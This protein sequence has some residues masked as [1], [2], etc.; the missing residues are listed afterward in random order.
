A[1][2]GGSM[3]SA[4]LVR[5]AVALTVA[6]ALA[7]LGSPPAGSPTL[8]L[9]EVA[10]PP[11][12]VATALRQAL[13]AKGPGYEPRT[14]HRNPDGTPKYTNRLLLD[15]TPSLPQHAHT[16]VAGSPWGE[17]ASER[18]RREHRPILL[19]IGYSTC[20]WC[21]VMEEESFDDEEI[22]AELNR[23]YVAIKV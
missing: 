4:P 16:P 23:H 9:P 5:A 10:S 21:H 11:P 15:D 18:A 2:S 1:T 8:Q 6:L 12:A 19:S 14:R 7:R 22:A 20:H 3:R 13:A 17:E